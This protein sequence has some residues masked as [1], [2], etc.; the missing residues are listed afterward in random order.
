VSRHPARDPG[1]GTRSTT[2]AVPPRDSALA[3][4]RDHTAGGAPDLEAAFLTL[5]RTEA[6]P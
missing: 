2:Q 4:S 1:A 6:N 3:A 5:T